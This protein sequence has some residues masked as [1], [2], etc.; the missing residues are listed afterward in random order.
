M[1][2]DGKKISEKILEKIKK[3]VE[4]KKLN[5]KLAIVLV[6][7]DPSSK[8]YVRKKEEASERVGIDFELFDFPEDIEEGELIQEI[9]N[10]A[11]D[12]SI[13]GIVIQL[14]L[15]KQF[16]T[17]EILNLIPAD[18]DVEAI[19]P[20]VSAIEYILK[21]YGISLEDKKVV[22]VGKGVLV[23]IPVGDWLQKQGISFS[24]IENIKE[25]DVVIS[26][27]GQRNLITKN[28]VKEGV[29][30]ID[31]GGDVNSEVAEKASYFTP[32]IGGI[33]PITVACLLENLTKM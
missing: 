2:I 20:V 21:E 18:K 6:G 26:G 11:D 7:N 15:P 30:I 33:G 5:L 22:V 19:S 27:A 12:F 31:V 23:G 9:K 10:I 25:A 8:I 32:I 3:E 14:P 28:M 24:G 29:V 17:N 16:E 1:I 13:H 4:E